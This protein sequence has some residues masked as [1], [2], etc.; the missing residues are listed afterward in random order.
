MFWSV[1]L[2]S[3][4]V[5]SLLM[6][7]TS[8]RPVEGPVWRTMVQ[9]SVQPVYSKMKAWPSMTLKLLLRNLGLTAAT[10]EARTARS[11][12]EGFIIVRFVVGSREREAE[13][14]MKGEATRNDATVGD[15]ESERREWEQRANESRARESRLL[16]RV[17]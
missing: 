9:P 11:A 3:P 7:W 8:C 13:R 4:P 2:N 14:A 5:A 16:A 1:T 6:V 12:T 10:A 17:K 15:R